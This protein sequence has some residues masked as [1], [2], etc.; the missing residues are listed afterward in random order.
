[1]KS[2]RN[3]VIALLAV[4][5]GFWIEGQSPS[6]PVLQGFYPGGNKYVP[7]QV[8]K[9]GIL[10]TSGGGGGGSIAKTTNVL[11]GD[12]SGN[13]VDA[14]FAATAAGVVSLFNTCSGTQYL[15]ADGAC[16]NATSGGTVTNFTAG[17]LSPLFTTSV[18]TS[19]TTPAL[20]F[21][22][23]TF[24]AHKFY[25]NATGSTAAPTAASITTA[26]LPASVT[27]TIASG[28]VSLGTTKVTSGTCTSVI[29]GGTATGVLSTDTIIATSNADPTAVTGYTPATTGSLYVWAYPTADHTNFKLCNNTASDITPGSAVTLNW[30]VTR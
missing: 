21:T 24:T 13:A 7:F 11:K 1:M 16:H 19:T 17:T 20:T 25:G 2:I 28:T 27:Q 5:F 6:F 15:G 3:G 8:D 22:Q 12:G 9:N 4:G 26:D 10:K 23:S 18:A 14:N 30:R 29:D